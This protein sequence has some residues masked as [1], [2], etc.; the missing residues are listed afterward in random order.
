MRKNIACAMGILL[1][2]MSILSGCGNKSGNIKES[3]SAAAEAE[4]TLEGKTEP[5]SMMETGEDRIS[6][7]DIES[8][9]RSMAE[10]A[11]AEA[12]KNR[13]TEVASVSGEDA[14]AEEESGEK[15]PETE[16]GTG[17][18][19]GSKTTAAAKTTAA[20]NEGAGAKPEGTKAT[21]AAPTQAPTAAPTTAAPT[22]APTTVAPT[23]APT[24]AAPTEPPKLTYGNSGMAFDTLAEADAWADNYVIEK[25]YEGDFSING[26]RAW[27]MENGQWTVDFY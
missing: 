15:K 17:P 9:R 27:T 25:A 1:T 14:V 13:E 3:V 21:T 2:A 8:V 10:S 22:Q 11:V 4:T 16:A 18:Q 26:Y 20:K 6:T 23:Q 7:E 5:E 19:S 24:T 12:L